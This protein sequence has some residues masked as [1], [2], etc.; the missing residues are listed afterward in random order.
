MTSKSYFAS[1]EM[2]REIERKK[3]RKKLFE[4]SLDFCSSKNL[5][6]DGTSLSA[7][8]FILRTFR[9]FQEKVRL[10]QTPDIFCKF[11]IFYLKSVSYRKKM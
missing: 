3:E 8:A 10:R 9:D 4:I 2:R 7:A 6:F 11:E 1:D 5:H